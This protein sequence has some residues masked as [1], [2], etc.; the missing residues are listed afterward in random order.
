MPVRAR[1]LLIAVASGLVTVGAVLLLNQID[2]GQAKYFKYAAAI[3]LFG[4]F[5]GL[6]ELVSGVPLPQ[7]EKKWNSLSG[8]TRGAL[9]FLAIVIALGLFVLAIRIL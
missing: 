5:W 3:P 8:G 6:L 2:F 9:S 7:L 4:V 1:G